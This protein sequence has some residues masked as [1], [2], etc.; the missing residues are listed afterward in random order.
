MSKRRGSKALAACAAAAMLALFG[1]SAMPAAAKQ[2][3]WNKGGFV[4]RV[5]W[6]KVGAITHQVAADGYIEFTFTEQ[7]VQTDSIWSGSGRCI[8]RGPVQYQ[9]LLSVC[10]GNRASRV[11][12]YPPEWPETNRIDCNINAIMA[13]SLTRYLDVWGPVWDVQSGEGGPL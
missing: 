2:C 1:L 3:V 4:L 5:D 10:G 13:P 6:F 12:S 11:V 7:P 8:D 9:A